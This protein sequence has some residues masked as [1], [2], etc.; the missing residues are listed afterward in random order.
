MFLVAN[1]TLEALLDASA[2]RAENTAIFA[3]DRACDMSREGGVSRC[4]GEDR[5]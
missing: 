5:D 4:H 3:S 2:Q 1:D